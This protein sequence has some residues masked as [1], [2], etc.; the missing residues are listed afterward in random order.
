MGRWLILSLAVSLGHSTTV[1]D[2]SACWWFRSHHRHVV[3][4]PASQPLFWGGH[5]H[6]WWGPL[7]HGWHAGHHCWRP[8]DSG[9][10]CRRPPGPIPCEGATAFHGRAGV[11]YFDPAEGQ[12]FVAITVRGGLRHANITLAG[13]DRDFDYFRE[14]VVWTRDPPIYAEWALARNDTGCGHSTHFRLSNS[15]WCLIHDARRA[16]VAP[17]SRPVGFPDGDPGQIGRAPARRPLAQPVT[18]SMLREIHAEMRLRNEEKL[19]HKVESISIVQQVNWTVAPMAD[20][21]TPG[22][23]TMQPQRRRVVTEAG[24]Q[25][26]V[27]ARIRIEPSHAPGIDQRDAIAF[28]EPVIPDPVKSMKLDYQ[29][30]RPARKTP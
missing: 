17:G 8:I 20:D 4:M 15:G 3:W 18:Q 6:G 13:S 12:G 2:A 30:T 11:L 1:S 9:W 16:C 5:G 21:L 14:D 23:T 28:H 25:I 22:V 19:A 7:H 26:P 27:V 24:F 10:C 29:V